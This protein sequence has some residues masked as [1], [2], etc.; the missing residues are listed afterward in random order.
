MSTEGL[1]RLLSLPENLHGSQHSNSN[2]S[3]W[4]GIQNNSRENDYRT[5]LDGRGGIPCAD[6]TFQH[7]LL[8]DGRALAF[9]VAARNRLDVRD[10]CKYN[11][12]S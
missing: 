2:I 12:V 4:M 7:H 1:Q 9:V 3:I 8:E 6:R 11:K 10:V 5:V